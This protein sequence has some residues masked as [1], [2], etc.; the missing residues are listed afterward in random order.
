MK[1]CVALHEDDYRWTNSAQDR[2]LGSANPLRR[3]LSSRGV[4]GAGEGKGDVSITPA[5][6]RLMDLQLLPW[7][8]DD[9]PTTSS[10]G[11]CE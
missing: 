9:D 10:R 5:C 7:L 6:G 8:A 4:H 11:P 2:Q 3:S 1:K